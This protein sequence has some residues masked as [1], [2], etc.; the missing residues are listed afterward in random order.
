MYPIKLLK[1]KSLKMI[2]FML[3][4]IDVKKYRMEYKWGL[5]DVYVI[6]IIFYYDYTIFVHELYVKIQAIEKY[7]IK[8]IISIKYLGISPGQV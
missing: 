7:Y 8:S 2:K 6:Y 4:E 3:S 1:Y 5:N